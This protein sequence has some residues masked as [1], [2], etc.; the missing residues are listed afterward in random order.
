ML[1][2]PGTLERVLS[3]VTLGSGTTTKVVS[4]QSDQALVSYWVSAISGT[5]TIN[6][7]H[8]I[9]DGK[10]KLVF[11]FGPVA[12]V[13]TELVSQLTG[14]INARL[15]I[16]AVYTGVCNYEI[17]V[18]AIESGS[19]GGSA[20][21]VIIDDQPI[22]VVVTNP[23]VSVNPVI[24]NVSIPTANTEVSYLLP[25]GT[26]KFYIKLR[27]ANANMK[28]AYIVGESGTT[29]VT[30]HRGNWYGEDTLTVPLTT[31]YFQADIASQ[32]AEIVSWS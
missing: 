19:G 4:I 3:E 32:V 30:V 20:G 12:S 15:R 11:S 27:E 31:I 16:E 7:Y 9:D 6:V 21:H 23:E 2:H 25:A 5:L 14:V 10:E 17:Y 22:D 1:V 24:A 8:Q 13:S 18:R 26:K 29:Y 28:V